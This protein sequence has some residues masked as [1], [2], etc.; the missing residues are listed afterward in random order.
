MPD[1][2][3]ETNNN[4]SKP[5]S[6]FEIALD[7]KELLVRQEFEINS[8]RKKVEKIEVETRDKTIE[9]WK[10]KLVEVEKEVT[11]RLTSQSF[12]TGFVM[13]LILTIIFWAVAGSIRG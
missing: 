4:Y 8:L 11:A 9:E 7:Q 12:W 5:K 6:Q 13:G 1:F 2:D 10:S 3:T